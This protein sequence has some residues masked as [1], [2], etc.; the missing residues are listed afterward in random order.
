MKLHCPHCGNNIQLVE[1]QGQEVICQNCGSS[2]RVE[3][4]TTTAS[5]PSERP[6][7]IG[8]FQVLELLGRGAFGTVYKARD[9]ELERIVAIKVPR[10]GYFSTPEEEQRFLREARSA[11]R[12]RH[13]GIVPV[14]EIAHAAG[15]PYI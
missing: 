6:T 13:S 15:L 9:P 8:K 4:A 10:A 12:L 7:A 11:A 5:G 3:P 2:F 1:P 14:Y